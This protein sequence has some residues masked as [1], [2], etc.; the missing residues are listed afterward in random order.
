MNIN[1]ACQ[2]AECADSRR[3]ARVCVEW[4]LCVAKKEIGRRS[5]ETYRQRK[6]PAQNSWTW[7]LLRSCDCRFT[8]RP[9][10][11]PGPRA[12]TKPY[13]PTQINSRAPKHVSCRYPGSSPAK[14][15]PKFRTVSI[16]HFVADFHVYR[17]RSC[18]CT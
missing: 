10:F 3:L 2:D 14:I 7:V 16:S 12:D 1:S 4:A 15:R 11:S 5:L 17:Q 18:C 13:W 6:T 8:A 9:I